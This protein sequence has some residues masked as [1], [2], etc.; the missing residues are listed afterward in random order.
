MRGCYVRG[1]V[2]LYIAVLYPA[3][4]YVCILQAAEVASQQAPSCEPLMMRTTAP[5]LT[6][7]G[8]LQHSTKRLGFHNCL[9]PPLRLQNISVLKCPAA[10]AAAHLIGQSVLSC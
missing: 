3:T 4:S 8:R 7:A 6:T 2:L 5:D 1:P 9:K 10:S